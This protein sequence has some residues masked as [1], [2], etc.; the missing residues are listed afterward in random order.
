MNYY[1]YNPLHG[2]ETVP[3]LENLVHFGLQLLIPIPS[4]KLIID[5]CTSEREKK[6]KGFICDVNSVK[7]VAIPD[8][9]SEEESISIVRKAFS[10]A[11][12]YTDTNIMDDLAIIRERYSNWRTQN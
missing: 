11:H 6:L 4:I 5:V 9:I 10:E 3:L 1:L 8:K 12:I 2:S 7:Y